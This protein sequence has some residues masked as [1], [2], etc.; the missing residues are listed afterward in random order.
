MTDWKRAWGLR[1]KTRNA[2]KNKK[3]LKRV[4]HRR[5]RTAGK[6]LE[7]NVVRLNG[8]DVI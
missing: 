8:W 3:A 5:N 6:A 2:A 4:N 1:C 7:K